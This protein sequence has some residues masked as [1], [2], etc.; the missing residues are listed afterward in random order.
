MKCPKC[1][2]TSFPYL[3][4]CGKC[5]HGLAEQRA[6][7][8]IYALR[9]DPPDLLL[10]YQPADIEATEATPAQPLLAPSID[11]GTLDEIELEF[12]EAESAAPGTH[13]LEEQG[14]AA[15]DSGPTFDLEVIE[16]GELPPVEP[17]AEQV[18]SQAMIM[19]QVSDLSELGDFTLELE[20]AAD[21][22]GESPE[23]AQTPRESPEVQQVYDLDLSDDLDAVLPG[24]AVDASRADEND[25]DTVEY[26]LQIEDDLQLEVY[27]VELEEEDEAEE[28]GDD[29]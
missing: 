6:A 2:Y 22:G 27:E 29:R 15:S 28:D 21:L 23:S 16:E 7:M 3:E 12:A 19:P 20:R 4:S 17:S 13:E 14:D 25:E 24:S 26:T 8:G 5:A 18:S 9:P 10:A 11:L 1:G